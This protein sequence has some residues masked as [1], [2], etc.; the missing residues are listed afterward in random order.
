M[1]TTQDI[2]YHSI[3]IRTVIPKGTKVIPATNL[4]G[5]KKY[6][7]E[8]WDGMN[9]KEESWQRSYGFL[10]DHSEIEK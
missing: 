3:G 8:S 5:D 9:E 7:T 2:S 1:K 6:W 10:V 4:P